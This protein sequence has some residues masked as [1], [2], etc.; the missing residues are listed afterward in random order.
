MS[1]LE[2]L[3]TWPLEVVGQLRAASNATLLC[4]L[5]DGTPCVYKPVRGERP[6]WDFPHG[7]LAGREIA[8]A[9]LAAHLR[10]E[11]IPPTTWREEGPFG[12]GM[13]Q[14]WFE[15]DASA[16]LVDVVAPG[17]AAAGWLVAFRG[18]DQDGHALELVH[19]DDPRLAAIALLDVVANNADRKGG[20][21]LP[22]AD[23]SIA[24]IDHGVCFSD[25]PKLRTVLWGWGGAE[26]ESALGPALPGIVEALEAMRGAIPSDVARWLSVDEVHALES[27]I[28]AIVRDRRF[29]A[30]SPT[31]PAIPWPVF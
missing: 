28:A 15:A 23:G 4:T 12:P 10:I 11:G 31:W 17:A 26:L 22:G 9:A 24:A 3:A 25:E 6:L 2:A 7:T 30:P 1:G 21:L 13:C 16:S 5:P 19:R 20:H 14:A 29:P 8:T 27:R 18:E